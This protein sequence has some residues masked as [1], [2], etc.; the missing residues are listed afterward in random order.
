[1][2]K[3]LHLKMLLLLSLLLFEQLSNHRNIF[4][5]SL[6]SS[7]IICLVDDLLQKTMIRSSQPEVFFDKDVLK[8]Y[9]K[10][11][12]KHSCRSIISIKL[13]SAL[14]FSCKF[15]AYFQNT[16]TKNTSGGCFCMTDQS[17]PHTSSCYLHY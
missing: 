13:T 4:M 14:V 17:T 7:S 5:R 8:I 6:I 3:Y 10:F 1:M 2:K 9:I 12:G 16:F 11:T 15:A